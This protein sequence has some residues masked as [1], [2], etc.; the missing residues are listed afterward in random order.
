MP[1]KNFGEA[2]ALSSDAVN[3]RQYTVSSP[4]SWAV[5]VPRHVE[6]NAPVRLS[7]ASSL[8]TARDMSHVALVPGPHQVSGHL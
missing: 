4:Y 8:S 3:D 7:R 2:S 5:L 6:F 1:Q